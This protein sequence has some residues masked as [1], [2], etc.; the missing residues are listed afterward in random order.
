MNTQENTQTIAQRLA[1]GEVSF[2]YTK[3]NGELREARG[4]TNEALMLANGAAE[5][6]KIVQLHNDQITYYDLNVKGIRAFKVAN[7][8]G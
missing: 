8:Q 3:T 4:T 2:K 5:G 7:L 6:T 1:E